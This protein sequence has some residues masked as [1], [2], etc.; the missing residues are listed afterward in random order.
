M[1]SINP[2]RANAIAYPKPTATAS[3]I[4]TDKSVISYIRF[5]A[6]TNK[7]SP[8]PHI[9]GINT[10]S[11]IEPIAVSFNIESST[12][13]INKYKIIPKASEINIL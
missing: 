9:S 4:P 5:K 11:V 12:I 10:S 13:S 2:S 3:K 8:I 1:E 6:F 7:Y